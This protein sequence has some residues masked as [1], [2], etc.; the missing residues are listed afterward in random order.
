MIFIPGWIS[1]TLLFIT[2]VLSGYQ[3]VRLRRPNPVTNLQF[4]MIVLSLVMILIITIYAH[5]NV[6]LSLIFFV[7]A[8]GCL[9]FMLR[10]NR[11]LPPNR[12]FE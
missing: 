9:A 1:S 8:A 12:R 6:W 10:Q 7:I 5:T 4:S 11:M 2:C 3:H